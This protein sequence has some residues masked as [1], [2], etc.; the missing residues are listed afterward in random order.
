MPSSTNC[1]S[2]HGTNSI[3]CGQKG[4]G[5]P[6]QAQNI[7]PSDYPVCQNYVYNSKWGTCWSN[8]TE[9]SDVSEAPTD[10]FFS[11]G[12]KRNYDESRAY[13]L[14]NG[15]DLASIHNAAEHALAAAA[16]KGVRLACTSSYQ[17]IFS[18]SCPDDYSIVYLIFL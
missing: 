14:A 3:C 7:C 5:Y 18:L 4:T 16:K 15:A 12:V 17:S 2:D 1:A 10:V 8:N 9:F 11:D 13:C 6:S